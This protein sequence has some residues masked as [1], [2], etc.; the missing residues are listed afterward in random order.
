MGGRF[1]WPK[2][3]L[4]ASGVSASRVAVFQELAARQR[5]VFR[6]PVLHSC[7]DRVPV[8]WMACP[9][10]ALFHLWLRFGRIGR[11]EKIGRL[12]AIRSCRLA[13]CHDRRANA[14]AECHL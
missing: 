11:M 6:S 12:P 9:R 13:T 4:E 8:V 2:V 1:Y 7:R 10:I 14:A 5:F 3:P